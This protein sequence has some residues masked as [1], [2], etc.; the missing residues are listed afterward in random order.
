MRDYSPIDL[1][2]LGETLKPTPPPAPAP[3]PWR[4]LPNHPDH[5]TNGTETRLRPGRL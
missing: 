5:E 2:P 1:P 3:A 4:P